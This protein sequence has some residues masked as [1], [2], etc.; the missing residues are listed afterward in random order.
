M[1]SC[2]TGGARSLRNALALLTWTL[3]LTA[4]ASGT[5]GTRVPPPDIEPALLVRAPTQLPEAKSG[6]FEDLTANHRQVTKE[7]HRVITQLNALIDVVDPQA[8]DDPWYEF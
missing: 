4:C 6:A 2:P 3:A 5:R 1:T 8:D 7:C